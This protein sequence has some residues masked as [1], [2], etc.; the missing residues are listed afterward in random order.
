[1]QLAILLLVS[2]ASSVSSLRQLS[3][4]FAIR[5]Q[6]F[7]L[8]HLED[9]VFRQRPRSL[10]VPIIV[11][12]IRGGYSDD[13]DSADINNSESS[14]AEKST[15]KQCRCVLCGQD[16]LAES[17]ADCEAHMA[18]CTAFARVHPT[19]GSTNPNGVYPPGSEPSKEEIPTVEEFEETESAKDI[20]S[21]SVKELK[22][23]VTDAGLSHSD[24]IEKSDL[25]AR[26]EKALSG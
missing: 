9:S 25:Q 6:P 1:M 22:K 14:T 19:D 8:S 11:Q 15:M 26:A 13:D 24:C 10:V 21:M 2:L 17:Q 20:Y 3:K 4:P 23:I 12:D 7:E 5:K 16:F 18:V